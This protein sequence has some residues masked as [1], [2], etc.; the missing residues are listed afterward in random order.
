MNVSKT[1]HLP[2]DG[3]KNRLRH[4]VVNRKYVYK[5]LL[6]V[7]LVGIHKHICKPHFPR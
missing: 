7:V 5:V 3:H 6:L 1:L 2:H 4:V